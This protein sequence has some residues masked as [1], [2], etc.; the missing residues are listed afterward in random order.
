MQL[1]ENHWPEGGTPYYKQALT[2][3]ADHYEFDKNA[4]WKDLPKFAQQVLLNGSGDD[5]IKFRFDDGGRVYEVTRSYEGVIPI[6]NAA[7]SRPTATG[8]AKSSSATRTTAPA[9]P[10]KATACGP[11]R[12]R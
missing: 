8:C 3:I 5:E 10:A 4:R 6:S 12:W 7:T 9:A 2:A 1:A 11:R